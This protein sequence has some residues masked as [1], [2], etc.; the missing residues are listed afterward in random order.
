VE[1][2]LAPRRIS[3]SQPIR[4]LF[5]FYLAKALLH[6]ADCHPAT[7]LAQHKLRFV[8][9]LKHRTDPADFGFT[10]ALHDQNYA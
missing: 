4:L 7:H 2:R 8:P 10:L 5:I 3:S 6:A 1:R 9:T